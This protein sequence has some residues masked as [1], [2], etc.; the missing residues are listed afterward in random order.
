MELMP[1]QGEMYR[2]LCARDAA[3]DGLFFVGVR[4]TGIFC[5]PVCPARKPRRENVEFF[6]SARDALHAGYRPCKRCHPVDRSGGPAPWVRRLMDAV[7]LDPL[8]RLTD[9]DLRAMDIEPA[10][11]RRYFNDYYG[12]TF[13]AYHRARRVGMALRALREGTDI[14]AAGYDHGFESASGFRSAFARVFGCAPGGAA[15]VSALDARWLDTP[16]GA[17]VAVAGEDGVCLLEFVDRRGLESQLGR[18]RA[19]LGR[20][21]VPGANAHLERLG[22][23]LERYFDGRLTRFETP[24]AAVGTEFQRSVWARLRAIPFAGTES[25]SG[26]A[27]AVGRPGA[28]R[29]VGSAN[30][31]N[32]VAIVVPCHRVVR[33]DGTLG[34]YGGGLWRKRW[35]LAHERAACPGL[36][37]AQETL[38]V[39]RQDCAGG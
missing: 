2:A 36:A 4:S 12:M 34:G 5:R 35:L 10:R 37:A 24:V 33:D 6:T 19:R 23:E 14:M 38:R 20:A 39:V 17:M 13:H 27:R 1:R 7:E 21:V 18:L 29:A 16:L 11:A 26:I 15:A 8:R 31:A 3:Y 30:G 22:G 28:Q 32:P 9:A 25:Y